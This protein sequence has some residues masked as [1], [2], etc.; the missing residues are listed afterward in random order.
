MTIYIALIFLAFI[1]VLLFNHKK[2]QSWIDYFIELRAIEF[3]KRTNLDLHTLT[4]LS[5]PTTFMWGLEKFLFNISVYY[6]DDNNL[7]VIKSKSPVVQHAIST[8]TE[9]RKTNVMINE[10][11]VWKIIIDD[12][13]KRFTYKI[14]SYRNFNLFLEMV[15]QNPN[16][17][18][19][20]RYLWKI[21]E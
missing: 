3:K 17:I 11:R 7:Y 9:M 13:G 1:I 4:R 20:E 12:S 21:F 15:S 10:R 8:I 19:D 2:I 14:R 16:A 5:A 18:V 6:F